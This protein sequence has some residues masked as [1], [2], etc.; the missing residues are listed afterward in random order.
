[1]K[2]SLLIVAL[3]IVCAGCSK[4][5]RSAPG[6]IKE[7]IRHYN[8]LCKDAKVDEYIFQNQFVF[9]FDGGTC[10]RDGDAPVY[11]QSCEELGA[12]GGITGNTKIQGVEF[13]S[14]AVFEKTIWKK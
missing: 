6:C 4:I 11:N 13:F 1:M 3:F 10:V 12:L 9:V 14:E 8:F 7:K 2:T 5:D